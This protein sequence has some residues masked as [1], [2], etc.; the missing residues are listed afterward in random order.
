MKNMSLTFDQ[1]VT[2]LAIPNSER[3]E[4]RRLV[5]SKLN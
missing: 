5:K 4:Y 1:T 3:E 2:V